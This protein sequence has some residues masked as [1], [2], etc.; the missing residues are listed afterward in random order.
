MCV[1]YTKL[2]STNINTVILDKYN[3]RR[4]KKYLPDST[5]WPI[6]MYIFKDAESISG[7][8]NALESPGKDLLVHHLKIK[9]LLYK[10]VLNYGQQW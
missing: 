5:M 9:I 10:V 7:T 1:F 6:K 4:T 3:K 8:K 2:N